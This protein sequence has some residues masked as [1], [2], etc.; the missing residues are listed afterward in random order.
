M[1]KIDEVGPFLEVWR[2]ITGY[3]GL[4]QVSNYGRIKSLARKVKKKGG[5][6]SV[7]SRIL[8]LILGG[9]GYLKVNLYKE[10]IRKS[11]NVHILVAV[12]FHY[13]IPCGNNLVVNHIKLIKTDNRAVNLE[14]V[15]HRVNGNMKHL[16]STSKY[17]G[18]SWYKSSSKWI[19][20]INVKGKKKHLGSFTE[21]LDAHRAYQAEL[22]TLS[23]LETI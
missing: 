15:T 19:A 22:A 17:T 3:E 1:Y 11:R 18:V 13:H 14:I 6:R 4:Y 7:K 9:N 12:A 5:L 23:K 21:E 16:K 2:D 20:E 10:G 8:T